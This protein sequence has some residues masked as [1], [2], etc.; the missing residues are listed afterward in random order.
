MQRNLLGLCI[1]PLFES[2]INVLIYN[3]YCQDSL[4][5]PTEKKCLFQ[6]EMIPEVIS[7]TVE[8]ELN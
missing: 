1:L 2:F 4:N 5:H 6:A 8:L 7:D 3:K